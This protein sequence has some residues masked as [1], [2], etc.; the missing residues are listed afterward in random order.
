MKIVVIL[1]MVPDLVE[2]LPLADGR[3]AWD[4]AMLA[5]NEF[6]DHALEEA[7]LLKE[8]TGATVIALALANCGDRV[9]RTALA[10]GADRVVQITASAPED[11]SARSV[12][13]LFAEAVR[14]EQADV[15]LTGVQAPGD[16][17]GG[18]AP[19]LAA[20][21]GWPAVDG[22]TA[23]SLAAGRARVAQECGAGR[24]ARLAVALPAVFGIQAARQPPRYV[25]GSRLRQVAGND[26]AAV[27]TAARLAD[28][29]A[30][31]LALSP[32]R[33]ARAVT[34]VGD[35]PEAAAENILVALRARGLIGRQHG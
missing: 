13:P 32:P 12:A 3:I 21:L 1:R 19:F 35:D 33:K 29:P 5:L 10:R 6:D 31:L 9:L 8:E 22:V 16:L 14:T 34:L 30:R 28:E 26:I 18:L 2:A 20:A 7:V 4:D 27:A 15:V 17:F 11:A 25:S 24:T 23:V